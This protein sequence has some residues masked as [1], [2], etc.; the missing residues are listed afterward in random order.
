MYMY[1]CT[2]KRTVILTI[3][4]T[5][6]TLHLHIV[7]HTH[8]TLNCEVRLWNKFITVIMEHLKS[9]IFIKHFEPLS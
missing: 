6:R 5:Y 7:C 4:K 8:L 9:Y 3:F 2:R 1:T